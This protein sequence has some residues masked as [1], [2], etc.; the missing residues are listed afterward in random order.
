MNMKTRMAVEG[1]LRYLSHTDK[2][3]MVVVQS[4]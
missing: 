4:L 3:V 2:A 1:T